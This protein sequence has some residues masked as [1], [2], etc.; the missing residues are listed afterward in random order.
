MDFNAY[1]QTLATELRGRECPFPEAEYQ[2][3][4]KHLRAS[5][6][7]D[8]LGAVLLTDP[9]DLFYLTGYSTFEV[10]VHVA[11]VVTADTLTLQVPSIETGPAM[12]T[13]GS[14]TLSVT[15]GKAWAMCW[16]PWH[17]R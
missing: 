5:M 12:V 4:L 11:L 6:H 3:R 10:S 17:T 1:Q 8:G 7:A 2:Q 9:S 15:V 16:I 14:I 13:H